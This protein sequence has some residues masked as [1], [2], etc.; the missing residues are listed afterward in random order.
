MDRA[1]WTSTTG[2]Q[3]QQ[4]VTE[5]IANNLAN[6]NT[7]GYKRGS[8][9]FQDILY[10]SVSS[11]GASTAQGE[12]PVGIEI[13]SG[14]RVVGIVKNFT[15]GSMKDTGI[16]S[17]LGIQG[18]GFFEVTLPD[19]TKAYTRDGSFHKDSTGKFVT[20]N[21]YEVT[22]IPAI[23]SEATSFDIR[24]DGTVSST[25]AGVS[26][27]KGRVTLARFP[28]PGG[29]KPIGGNLYVETTASGTPISA[30][31]S[32]SGNGLILQ[33]NLESSNVQVVR[34]MVDMIAAQR[35]Y[36]IISKSIKTSDEMLRNVTNLK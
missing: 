23:E 3:G 7:T 36:E 15:Q 4:R 34:E 6:V 18:D 31:A 9:Q 12:T 11:A 1:L 27:N 32:E 5:N 25:V 16:S 10:Q 8:V 35:A 17:N 30:N 22:S 33:N 14:T 13:G 20:A 29:L 26:S 28:N 21:G 24:E 19:G 2:M